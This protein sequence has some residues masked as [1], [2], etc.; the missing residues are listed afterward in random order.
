MRPEADMRAAKLIVGLFLAFT[1]QAAETREYKPLM[2]SAAHA[3]DQLEQALKKE[4][5][6]AA[7]ASAREL[8]RGMEQI[9]AF[10]SKRG[11]ADAVKWATNVKTAAG[12]VGAKADAGDFDAAKSLLEAALENCESCHKAHR[13]MTFGGWKIK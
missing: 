9:V 1:L 11:T 12:D 7:S 3:K 6:P 4:D 5:G 10:W 2:K 13:K 8:E